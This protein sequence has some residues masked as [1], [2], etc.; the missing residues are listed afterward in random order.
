MY[1]CEYLKHCLFNQC[2]SLQHLLDIANCVSLARPLVT[3]CCERLA[4]LFEM[5]Q[6]LHK[7]HPPVKHEPTL[8]KVLESSEDDSVFSEPSIKQEA[9]RAHAPLKDIRYHLV[10]P[11]PLES[12]VPNLS[13]KQHT[14]TLLHSNH[15]R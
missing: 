10:T 12:D 6:R 1:V 11:E 2:W 7:L 9:G 13:Y 5:E 8:E 4:T 15:G 3:Y 14:C